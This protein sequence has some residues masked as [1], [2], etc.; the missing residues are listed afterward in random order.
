MKIR[1]TFSFDAAHR[2]DS[3]HGK[4]ERLHGHTYA[5]SLTVEGKPDR[6]GMVLDFVELKRLT[7]LSDEAFAAT[8]AAFS[9]MARKAKAD[10]QAKEEKPDK[11]EKKEAAKTEDDPPMR[12]DAGVRPR[13]VDDRKTSLEDKLR[14]GFMAAYESRVGTAA[15][16]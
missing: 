4:C 3:Y 14:D 15:N 16:Q 11:Q 2:L 12:S 6:E 13:D 7:E 9:R 10:A 8:E 5:F 1:R